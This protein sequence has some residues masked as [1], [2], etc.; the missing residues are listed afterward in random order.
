MV[1]Y[2]P[3]ATHRNGSCAPPQVPPPDPSSTCALSAAISESL[4]EI[5][6]KFPSHPWLYYFMVVL[7]DASF[8][9]ALYFSIVLV[10]P[11]FVYIHRRLF[12][13]SAFFICISIILC[14]SVCYVLPAVLCT[15]SSRGY[16]NQMI[17]GHFQT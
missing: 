2:R 15:S 12:C 11:A 3:R 6:P 4:L 7:S 16:R 14:I 5:P 13:V 17:S 10:H 1:N 8:C 9:R